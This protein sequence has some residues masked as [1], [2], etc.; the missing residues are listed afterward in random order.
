[1]KLLSR[2]AGVLPLCSLAPLRSADLAPSTPFPVSPSLRYFQLSLTATA[3]LISTHF[4]RRTNGP[5]SLF[6]DAIA[7]SSFDRPP[8]LRQTEGEREGE[9]AFPIGRIIG[10]CALLT[11]CRRR[12]RRR[13]TY[14]LRLVSRA[15]WIGAK[16]RFIWRSRGAGEDVGEGKRLKRGRR[17]ERNDFIDRVARCGLMRIRARV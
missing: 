1:M 3:E 4:T 11:M 17:G 12:R 10:S 9:R 13:M 14:Y 5:I 8:Y 16:S 6:Q 7:G 15:R 2:R